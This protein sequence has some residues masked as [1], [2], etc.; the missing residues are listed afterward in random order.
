M[1]KQAL[2]SIVMLGLSVAFAGCKD[3]KAEAARRA[4]THMADH[5]RDARAGIDQLTRTFVPV[6]EGLAPSLTQSM[7]AHDIGGVR[8][9]LIGM[10]TEH[11]AA[12][13]LSFFP[14]GFITAVGP[15][16]VAI[17]RNTDEQSDLM[18]G[19]N[20]ANLFPA[21]RDALGGHGTLGVGELPATPD[22]PS[23]AYLIAT[24]PV[25]DAQN[26]VIGA[27]AAGVSYGQLAH[28]VT[29][30]VRVHAG[31]EPVLWIGLERGGRVLPSGRDR[32]VPERWLVPAALIAQIPPGAATHMSGPNQMTTWTFVEGGQRGWA[33]ALAAVP[34]LADTRVLIYRSEATQN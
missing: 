13:S 10:Q 5:V 26:N 28:A 14:T 19:T 27:L 11:T 8:F 33:G 30:A 20:M 12:G 32:D 1:R 16:G 2:R 24:V 7:T 9:A 22:Q 3:F 29:T 18:R 34:Q 21:I 15:D 4:E 6:L 31:Q 23:R 17:A 25:H